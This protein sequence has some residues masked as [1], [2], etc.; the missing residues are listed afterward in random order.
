[1]SS[2]KE[3]FISFLMF[4]KCLILNINSRNELPE[5]K[6]EHILN[7]KNKETSFIKTGFP[8]IIWVYWE[9]EEIPEYIQKIINKTASLNKD[10]KLNLLH[11]GMI[12]EYLPNFI[13]EGEMPIAN[14]TDLLRLMLLYEYG[15]VWVDATT[16]F[17]ENFVWLEKAFEE[18]DYD[19]IGYYK[20]TSTKDFNYPVIE[21]WFLSSK[22]KN[23]LIKRWLEELT[24]LAKLGSKAYFELISQKVDYN[25]IKQ[26]IN[27]PEYLLIYL[28][29][30][31]AL[32]D[33]KDFNIFIKR[34]EDSAFLIQESFRWVN[35][36][37]NYVLCRVAYNKDLPIIKL[38]SG[39]RLLIKSFIKHGF[40]KKNS[41]IGTIVSN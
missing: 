6:G 1:M 36:S 14:K 39:D 18:V 4:I 41:V 2:L 27:R 35:Y 32:R 20:E 9:D 12:K 7:I 21:S 37:I 24:P 38:T 31:I 28:A 13:I 40:L 17:Y 22:P 16:I 25:I 15:G 19:L 26:K 30:Q 8:K 11:K 3:E 10:Y 23:P 33:Y 5:Y 34:S 29:Q